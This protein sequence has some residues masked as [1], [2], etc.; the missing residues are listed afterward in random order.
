MIRD[1]LA[2][3]LR[4]ALVA[5]GIEP[6][7]TI[8]VERP[9][10]PEHGD[11]SSNVA[12]ALAKATKRPP[13]ELAAAIAD[14]LTAHPPPYVAEV[15][16]AGP[17]FVNFRLHHGWLHDV[18]RQVVAAGVDGYARPDLGGGRSVNVE[19]VSAN[20]TGPLHVGGGRWAAYGDSLCRLLERTGHRVHREYYV[21]DRGNQIA[22]FGESMAA[23]RAGLPPPENG[24]RGGY[25]TEWAAEMPDDA[26]AQEWAEER[27]LTD[28]R[29]T[30]GRMNV[31]FDT[32]FSERSM[33]A[34]GAI[35][36]ALADLTA[37]G[38]TFEA[39]GAV[40]LRATAFGL[41]KDEVLVK[42]SGEPTYLLSDI[43]YHRDKFERGF[44]HLIDI[45]G[46]DHHGHVARLKVGVA[47][48]GHDPDELE[49]LLGQLVT[50][51]R[52]GEVVRMG[53]RTGDF[54][55]LAEVLDEV[56]PDVARLTFLLQSID[57]RQSFD[58]ATVVSKSMD[59]PVFYVQYAH[60]RI[61]SIARVAAER[62]IERHPVADVDLG[63]LV[64]ARELDVLR[65]LAELPDVVADACVSRAP[66]K[67]TTWVRELAGR[68]AGF[69]H[70]CYVMGE[71]VGPELTQARLWLVE[72]ARVGLA[73]GLDLL[74]VGAPESM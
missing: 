27:V 38:S 44:E 7:A 29:A 65:S 15:T 72:S 31:T 49:I 54:V 71:G 50:I 22:L 19:F 9:A 18:L 64:H 55:E 33:V 61:A 26:D 69:Y 73:I 68:F 5:G 63:L 56:G 35:D 40:W 58:L 6:P 52:D 45:W 1:V 28:L 3:S 11:W 32:W 36:K 60:A 59:N 25:V 8:T 47:A 39:D 62:G 48:L 16:V 24:Y 4:A 20:P 10:R 57:T 41:G 74:G 23:A 66:H 37:R 43:A 21:N 12:L 70:D 13:R 67:V 46:A 53:K 30:L 17:G 2:E 34:S 51:L 14:R 42:G